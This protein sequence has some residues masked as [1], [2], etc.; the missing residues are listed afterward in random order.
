M[1]K[2][3]LDRIEVLTKGIKRKQSAMIRRIVRLFLNQV[4][5]RA[6][7]IASHTKQP[8]QEEVNELVESVNR[9]E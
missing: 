4:E 5:Q 9:E 2:S 8:T 7:T 6:S 3:D 1:F